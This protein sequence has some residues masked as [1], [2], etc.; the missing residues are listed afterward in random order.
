MAARRL[1][2]REIDHV[3]KQ[4]ADRRAQDVQD[5]EGREPRAICSEPAFGDR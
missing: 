5:L 4:P 1:R 2:A 3:A